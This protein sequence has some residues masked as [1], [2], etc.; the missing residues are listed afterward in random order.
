MIPFFLK[1]QKEKEKGGKMQ[2]LP[3][4]LEK[5]LPMHSVGPRTQFIRSR[6]RILREGN[7][8]LFFADVC[9]SYSHS[10]GDRLPGLTLGGDEN[11]ASFFCAGTCSAIVFCSYFGLRTGGGTDRLSGAW[12][13]RSGPPP[14]L[15]LHL[16]WWQPFFG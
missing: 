13:A 6:A 5:D 2:S 1:V 8:L 7:S 16:E 10:L 12:Q 3:V 14:P 9:R 11:D 4:L 15:H